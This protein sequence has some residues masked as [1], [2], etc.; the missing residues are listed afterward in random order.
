MYP[1]DFHDLKLKKYVSRGALKLA[2]ALDH[3]GIAVADKVVAELGASTGGFV[4]VLLER[5]A[6]R[7]YAVEK[8]Y[9]V[10]DWKLRNNP[11]VTVRERTD[12]RSVQLPELVDLV[13]IDIG[14]TRQCQVVPHAFSLL[15]PG[16]TILSLIKPQYEALKE[17]FFK[18]RITD[19]RIRVITN[20]VL[21]DLRKSG[22][23]VEKTFAPTTR[24]KNTGIQEI[25]LL[26][27]KPLG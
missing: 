9:G 16:G 5:G 26:I 23:D 18:G 1:V 7:V 4:Q 27:R 14:F 6:E 8:G 3:F 11:K 12:A 20:R 19:D 15:K 25:F 24:G 10:L 22:F 21:S 17:D 13:T 2:E